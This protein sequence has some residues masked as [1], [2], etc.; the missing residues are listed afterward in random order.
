[1][2]GPVTAYNWVQGTTAAAVVGPI[3]ITFTAGCNL[4]GGCGC[5]YVEKR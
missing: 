4:R 3:S 1:M 2:A 5:F